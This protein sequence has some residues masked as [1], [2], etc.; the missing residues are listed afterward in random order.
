M[1][2]PPQDDTGTA[3]EGR[4]GARDGASATATG[5]GSELSEAFDALGHETRLAIVEALA[6]ERRLSWQPRGLSFSELRETVGL[7][8]GGKFNYHL[9]KLRGR[10]VYQDGDEYVLTNAGLEI[11]GA[12]RAGRFGDTPE[13]T[14]GTIDRTCPVD[15][16][17]LEAV[18]DHGYLQVRCP[19]HGD[20]FAANL[21]PAAA[22]DRSIEE[23]HRLGIGQNRWTI[24]RARKET[25]PHCWRHMHAT[26]PA[27][28]PEEVMAARQDSG[29]SDHGGPDGDAAAEVQQTLAEFACD[30]CGLTFWLPV[31]VCVVDH[32]AVVAY[33]HEHNVNALE[34][35][36]LGLPH[37][38]G[39][40]GD[41]VQDDPVRIEIVV[42][43]HGA[44]HGLVVTL[45]GV[46]EILD[47]RE[48]ENPTL[49]R[50]GFD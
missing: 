15:G 25:C 21:P 47:V 24:E 33:Y 44:A 20:I 6:D 34:A 28:Y 19:E 1:D 35:V 41:V 22:T 37:V 10:F 49:P 30:D 17:D 32:P 48:V 18:Y 16:V 27:E 38:T 42:A 5:P 23:I 43:M 46:T 11:A 45:D 29:R 36:Y 31:S 3:R 40:N 4:I 39:A 14:S 13:P 8:D 26:A 9:D 12:V 50:P 2:E 7:R